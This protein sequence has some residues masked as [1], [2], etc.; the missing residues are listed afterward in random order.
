MLDAGELR[1]ALFNTFIFISHEGGSG[2]GI[3]R[4]MFS[5]FLREAADITGESQLVD[6]ADSFGEIAVCWDELGERFRELSEAEDPTAGLEGCSASLRRLA[7]MEQ[8]AWEQLHNT[9]K[10]SS[11]PD[12]G[13]GRD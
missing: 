11:A 5:R 9:A 2:G 12:P 7:D 10:D 1:M 3:F 4:Y 6:G 13:T 8:Q